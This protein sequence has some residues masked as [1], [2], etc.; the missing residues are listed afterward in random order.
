MPEKKKKMKVN[1]LVSGNEV[2]FFSIQ[3]E[4]NLNLAVISNLPVDILG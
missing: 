3:I 4:P 1:I 2:A